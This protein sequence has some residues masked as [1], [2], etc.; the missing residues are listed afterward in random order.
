MA[1]DR[2]S[3]DLA[4]IK[5]N[6]TFS[7]TFTTSISGNV[8]LNYGDN[9]SETSKSPSHTYTGKPPYII[10]TALTDN[11]TIT[12]VNISGNNLS[13]VNI[14]RLPNLIDINI[15][16][17]NIKRKDVENIIITLN[18]NGKTDGTLNALGNISG[19]GVTA[20]VASSYYGLVNSGWDLQDNLLWTPADITTNFW[21]DAMD[22]STITLDE[23]FN[24]Q[25]TQWDDKSG[26]NNHAVQG[27]PTRQPFYSA[28]DDMFGGRPSV[29][30]IVSGTGKYL[31]TPILSVKRIY[32][33]LYFGDGTYTKFPT[34]NSPFGNGGNVRVTGRTNQ[35]KW[36]NQNDFDDA[37]TYRDGSTTDMK[38]NATVN[39][40]P[41]TLWKFDSSILQT[42]DWYIMNNNQYYTNWEGGMGETIFTDGT[43]DLATQQKIEGYLAHKWGIVSNLPSDHPYKT[44]AP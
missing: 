38:A 15:S 12:S 4:I 7:G 24:T 10:N 14:A 25:V 17:N 9:T 16:D 37:G 34:H 23:T 28:S 31:F 19:S 29:Y 35:N 20:E 40:M 30:N 3:R 32:M 39:P 27:T 2:A 5:S 44:V 18:E 6:G 33:I 21:L 41:P 11:S 26:N 36:D 42:D 8:T 22:A 43:E 1:L 13:T